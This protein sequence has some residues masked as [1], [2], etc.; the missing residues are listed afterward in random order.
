QASLSNR[1]RDDWSSAT[2]R[3][4]KVAKRLKAV[5]LYRRFCN[6]FTISALPRA[7]VKI[8]PRYEYRVLNPTPD[9]EKNYLAWIAELDSQFLNRDVDHRSVVVRNALYEIY[10]GRP[11]EEPGPNTPP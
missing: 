10:L 2:H 9:A 8:M 7:K 6:P 4:T 5:H 11:Y 1:Y 3:D